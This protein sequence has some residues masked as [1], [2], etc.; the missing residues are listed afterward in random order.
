MGVAAD[1]AVYVGDI[2]SVDAAGAR[3]AGMHL[4]LI[5]PYGDYADPGQWS[6]RRLEQLPALLAERFTL[7]TA[8][9]GSGA[10]HS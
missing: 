9:K 8:R 1:R 4:V 6:V 3:G 2:K 10:A 5:D 7:V